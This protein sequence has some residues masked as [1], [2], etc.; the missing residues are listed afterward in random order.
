MGFVFLCVFLALGAILIFTPPRAC[1]M[2]EVTTKQD[3]Y[4]VVLSD[5]MNTRYA[6]G[7]SHGKSFYVWPGFGTAYMIFPLTQGAT[8]RPFQ[9]EIIVSEVHSDYFVLLV[10]IIS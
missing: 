10:R 1:T 5:D 7:Y 8:Y 2:I 6:F 3:R 9:L 4:N